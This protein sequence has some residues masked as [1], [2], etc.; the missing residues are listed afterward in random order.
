VGVR[1]VAI[2]NKLQKAFHF[3]SKSWCWSG[4]GAGAPTPLIT[5][6]RR[7][8]FLILFYFYFA[9][10]GCKKELRANKNI[11]DSTCY[12]TAVVSFHSNVGHFHV[13]KGHCQDALHQRRAQCPR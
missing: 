11:F 13:K 7:H 9:R 8:V 5:T 3:L 2:A 6:M 10:I 4:S 1:V 12:Y